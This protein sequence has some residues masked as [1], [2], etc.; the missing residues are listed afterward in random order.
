MGAGKDVIE[1]GSIAHLAFHQG[2]PQHIAYEFAVAVDKVVKHH[3]IVTGPGKG[4]DRMAADVAGS[5]GDEYAHAASVAP[6]TALK[7]DDQAKDEDE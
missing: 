2:H 4:P 5:A 1:K 3:N 6:A 7:G